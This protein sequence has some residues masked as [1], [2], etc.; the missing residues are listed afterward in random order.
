MLRT[1][2]D[3]ISVDETLW[4]SGP[5]ENITGARK[6]KH[7][8]STWKKTLNGADFLKRGNF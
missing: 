6:N 3:I 4:K 8:P 7:Q 2:R 5:G 1:R